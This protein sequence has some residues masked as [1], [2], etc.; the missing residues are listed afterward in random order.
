[1]KK[2]IATLLLSIAIVLGIGGTG[3][4]AKKSSYKTDI[5]DLAVQMNDFES[6]HLQFLRNKIALDQ[7]ALGKDSTLNVKFTKEI[8][9]KASALSLERIDDK[10]VYYGGND[11]M[12]MLKYGIDAKE[13]KTAGKNLFGKSLKAGYLKSK[14]GAMLD[15]YNDEMYGPV[16]YQEFGENN[17]EY[18][19]NNVSV[20]KSGKKYSV[21]KQAFFGWQGENNG[22]SN[23]EIIYTVK[24]SSKSKFGY[25]ITG[26]KI[27]YLQ[28]NVK[29]DGPEAS[30]TNAEQALEKV[31]QVASSYGWSLTS[32]PLGYGN[33][34]RSDFYYIYVSVEIASGSDGAAHALDGTV[35]GTPGTSIYWSERSTAASPDDVSID[36]F[37]LDM[38]IEAITDELV[39][40]G[41]K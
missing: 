4:S 9:T 23:V 16:V 25:I 13:L 31:K 12:E 37:F 10:L 36:V 20:K 18:K 29:S 15:A 35:T 17:V 1:M 32:Y 2:I 39:E 6:S 5:K 24:K 34:I 33:G 14:T 7:T 3:I 30:R 38:P 40:Y 21:T 8:M 22:S 19:V 27:K 41:V 11:F 26:M 28:N